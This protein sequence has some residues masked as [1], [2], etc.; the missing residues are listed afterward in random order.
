MTAR[1]KANA[2]ERRQM[3]VPA[4]VYKGR[5]RIVEHGDSV[6]LAL[7]DTRNLASRRRIRDG[8]RYRPRDLKA[9]LRKSHARVG[10]EVEVTF[11]RLS[12]HSSV[13][14]TMTRVARA[15]GRARADEHAIAS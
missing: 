1:S 12:L 14:L 2:T 13:V 4:G 11:A 15:A 10:D 8:A 3:A 7:V 9:W 5:G 6:A